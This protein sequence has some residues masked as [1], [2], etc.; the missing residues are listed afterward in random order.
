MWYW[1]AVPV[2]WEEKAMALC[3]WSLEQQEAVR[4]QPPHPAWKA[5]GAGAVGWVQQPSEQLE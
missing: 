2:A 4:Q 5:A 1:R 3:L